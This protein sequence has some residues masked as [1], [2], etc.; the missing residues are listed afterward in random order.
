MIKYSTTVLSVILYVTNQ[1][2]TNFNE[3][4]QESTALSHFY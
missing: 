1:L 4:R 2:G 3:W